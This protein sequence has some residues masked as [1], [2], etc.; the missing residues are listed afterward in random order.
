MIIEP[1]MGIYMILLPLITKSPTLGRRINKNIWRILQ[2]I[3]S[4]NYFASWDKMEIG[5]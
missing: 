5:S 4:L 3:I 2:F 1:N